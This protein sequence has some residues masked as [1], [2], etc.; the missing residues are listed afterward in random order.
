MRLIISKAFCALAMM[1][2]MPMAKAQ[3][4]V[5]DPGVSSA[6]AALSGTNQAG[7]QQLAQSNAMGNS[8]MVEAI[9]GSNKVLSNIN[10]VL[11]N[12]MVDV[13]K[14]QM[15][16][17][18]A[19][20]NAE[21]YDPTMGGKP[22]SSCGVLSYAT[23]STAGKKVQEQVENKAKSVSY[24]HIERYKYKEEGSG[25]DIKNEAA[26]N[27]LRT[28]E[29][30]N[31]TA[32]NGLDIKMAGFEGLPLDDKQSWLRLS[33]KMTHVAIPKPVDITGKNTV[34]EKA[35]KTIQAERQKM[36]ADI[37]GE[38]VSDRTK[39]YNTGWIKELITSISESGD[40]SGLDSSVIENLEK[41]VSKDEA[42]TILS[43][44]RIKSPGWVLY[45]TAK[46]N[47]VGLARDANIM[48]AQQLEILNDIYQ[49]NKRTNLLL[50]F[51]Y[52]HGI[53]QSGSPK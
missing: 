53:E 7:F 9:S 34:V 30:E 22:E 23:A 48:Q 3:V 32:E 6:V 24:S 20:Q 35:G 18:H 14:G 25:D 37:I 12:V 33:N 47:E 40:L 27:F 36:I 15:Q 39:V 10:Q 49:Q 13:A 51:I 31:L 44:Y 41:G 19:R 4:P 2:F 52:A 38:H 42:R 1:Q 21:L 17:A 43:T 29:A 5:T 28:M 8:A 45:T 50:N 11:A 46:A 16:V 26:T